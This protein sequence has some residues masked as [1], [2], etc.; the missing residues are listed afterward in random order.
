M[1]ARVML[2]IQCYSGLMEESTQVSLFL[3]TLIRNLTSFG[4]T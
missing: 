3:Y 2:A 4:D 1:A